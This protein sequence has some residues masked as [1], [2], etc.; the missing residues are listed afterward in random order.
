MLARF[1]MPVKDCID[2][3]EKLGEKVFGDPRHFTELNYPFIPSFRRTKYNADKLKK[4]FEEVTNRRNR[5]TTDE[6]RD[7]T[8]PT[9][10][11][12]CKV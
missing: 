2:E 7:M 1:R 12:L 9:E 10:Q 8:F 4:V 11:G 5:W 3:Y 6:T